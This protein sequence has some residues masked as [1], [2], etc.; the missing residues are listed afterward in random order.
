M[1]PLFFLVI[2]SFDYQGVGHQFP[3]ILHLNVHHVVF[4]AEAL[5]DLI[6]AIMTGG[7]EKFGTGV[8]D[9]FGLYPTIVDT[10]LRVRHSPGTATSTAAVVIGTCGDH[11]HI[12]FPHTAGQS[13][14]VLHNI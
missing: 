7:D 4:F 14:A 3:E 6:V 12:V 1:R 2:Y 13:S 11:F 9:L 5:H 8:F 10:L